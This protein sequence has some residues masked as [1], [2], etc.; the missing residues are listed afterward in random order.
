MTSEHDPPSDEDD[1]WE[2][3]FESLRTYPD[4]VLQVLL[5]LGLKPQ[6]ESRGHTASNFSSELGKRVLLRG[7]TEAIHAIRV[8]GESL[9]V[10]ADA[11]SAPLA[12]YAHWS[13]ARSVFEAS[14]YSVWLMEDCPGVK[15][16]QRVIGAV[17]RDLKFTSEF[18]SSH[19]PEDAQPEMD[20]AHRH[21]DAQR[22]EWTS[23]EE[24]LGRR[25]EP[26][27]S[28]SL[29]D[30]LDYGP[31]FRWRPESRMVVPGPLTT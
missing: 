19:T 9:K 28:T 24:Q 18:L 12:P 27:G 5:Q 29:A 31:E 10:L 1:V 25:V 21:N 2:P 11:R 30:R 4:K 3:V 17:L 26:P 14:G 7:Q 8:A 6:R 13:I 15:R 23:F 20:N 16:Q 22:A